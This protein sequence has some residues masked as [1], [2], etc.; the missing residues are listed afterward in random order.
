MVYYWNG[1]ETSKMS[2]RA[3]LNEAAENRGHAISEVTRLWQV[4]D[5]SEEAREALFDIS[6]YML[7]IVI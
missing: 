3:L 6:G 4:A 7:E 1:K 2:A 5:E